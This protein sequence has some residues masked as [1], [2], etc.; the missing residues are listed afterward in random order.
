MD[1]LQEPG[2]H[3][4]SPIEIRLHMLQIREVNEKAERLKGSRFRSDYKPV[5][6]RTVRSWRE[7]KGV[8]TDT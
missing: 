8:K 5:E 2:P 1:A 3:D 7:T 6:I 4:P